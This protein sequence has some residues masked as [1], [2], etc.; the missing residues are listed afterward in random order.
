MKKI[1][2]KVNSGFSLVEVTI[3]TAVM[4]VVLLMAVN[5]VTSARSQA[6][7]TYERAFAVQKGISLIEEVRNQEGAMLHRIEPRC[8][9]GRCRSRRRAGSTAAGWW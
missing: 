3:A 2:T 6:R 7:S 9:S 8:A 4:A 5:F 1:K